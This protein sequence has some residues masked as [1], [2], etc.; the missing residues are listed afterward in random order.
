MLDSFFNDLHNYYLNNNNN[1]EKDKDKELEKSYPFYLEIDPNEKLINLEN[2]FISRIFM[3]K[4]I[5]NNNINKN[6]YQIF[7]KDKNMNIYDDFFSLKKLKEKYNEKINYNIIN[8]KENYNDNENNNKNNIN[9]NSI[10]NKFRE[11]K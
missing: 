5:L 10:N 9:I 2:N 11:G 1:F 6:N 3:N 4:E 7:Q 8:D